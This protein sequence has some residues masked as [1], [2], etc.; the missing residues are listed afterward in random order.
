MAKLRLKLSRWAEQDLAGIF[1]F[2]LERWGQGQLADYR[3]LLDAALNRLV[4]DPFCRGTRQRD[5]LF[6]GCRSFHVGRHLILY[7]VKG[8]AVEVARVLYD[9]MELE[10]HLPPEYLSSDDS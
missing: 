4:R 1:D 8:D 3:D 6:P 2:T 9:A 10:R 5:E 7:R